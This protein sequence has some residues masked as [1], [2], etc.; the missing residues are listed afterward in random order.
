MIYLLNALILRLLLFSLLRLLL[1][2]FIYI[3]PEPS[4]IQLSI[5]F[6]QDGLS[7]GP[8][9]SPVLNVTAGISQVHSRQWDE[10][11][12]DAKNFWMLVTNWSGEWDGGYVVD[13]SGDNNR[14]RSTSTSDI[15]GG[16]NR[17]SFEGLENIHNAIG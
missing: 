6:Q 8:K 10:C 4:I 7:S 5:K 16:R 15:G 12:V 13:N 9:L 11:S 1:D 2:D 3:N 14:Y 17:R